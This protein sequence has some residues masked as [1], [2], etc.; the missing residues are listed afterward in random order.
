VVNARALWHCVAA[1]LIALSAVGIAQNQGSAL[2]PA[3]T[4]NVLVDR[5]LSS[6]LRPPYQ[7]RALRHLTATTRGGRMTASLDA[8]TTLQNGQFN[9]DVIAESGSSLIRHRVLLAA[10]EAER[11]SQTVEARDQAA[12]T[13]A[14]YE[15]L[16][17]SVAPDRTVRLD[18]RPRRRNV[19]LVDGSLYFQEQSADLVRV[20][21]ELS[22]R[23]SFWTRRVRIT[24][25]YQRIG[26]VNVVVAM[27]SN[28]DVLMAGDSMFA[29]TYEYATINDQ[30]VAR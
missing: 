19:M 29:M 11:D 23:P 12:L 14:N 9:F 10:L 7:Y 21:G 28:A 18:I 16:A 13:T 2:V 1:A 25:E 4:R 8:W 27:R 3:L 20:E 26:G 22:K 6:D 24:R 15:F 30:P 5:L 17:L